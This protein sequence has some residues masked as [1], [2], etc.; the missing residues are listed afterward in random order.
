MRIP[1]S[2]SASDK[3]KKK[4]GRQKNKRGDNIEEWTSLEFAKSKRAV[5]NREKWRKLVMKSFVAPQRLTV[6]G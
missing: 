2:Q 1:I 6:K 5:E 3:K 4:K